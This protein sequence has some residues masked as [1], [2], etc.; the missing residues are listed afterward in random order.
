MK[1]SIPLL[2]VVCVVIG[3]LAQSQEPVVLKKSVAVSALNEMNVIGKLGFPLGEVV[4]VQ[5]VVKSGR[6]TRAK[7]LDGQY[8]LH[9]E[10]VNGVALDTPV[11]TTFHVPAFARVMIASD[12]FSLYTLKT[13]KKT[14]SLDSK[15]IVELEQ[16]YVGKA[17]KLLVYESGCFHGIPHQLPKDVPVWQDVGFGFSTH[18]NVLAQRD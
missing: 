9:I 18:L 1:S 4:E 14:G 8:L 15:Q 12:H 13:G 2:L 16:G 17:V 11:N 10:S 6:A 5:A 3:A 7:A